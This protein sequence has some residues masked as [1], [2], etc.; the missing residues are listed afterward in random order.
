MA[1]RDGVIDANPAP[2]VNGNTPA[3]P[4][5]LDRLFAA[6]VQLIEL[7]KYRVHWLSIGTE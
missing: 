6:R 5:G 7:L 4:G 1:Q 3:R 2:P